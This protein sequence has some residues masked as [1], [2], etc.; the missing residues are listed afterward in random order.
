M[1]SEVEARAAPT[2]GRSRAGRWQSRCIRVA[3]VVSPSLI[4]FDSVNDALEDSVGPAPVRE[5]HRRLFWYVQQ[6]Y[7][8]SSLWRTGSKGN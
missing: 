3:I 7:R 8:R 6:G 1:F 4:V 5:N 2:V